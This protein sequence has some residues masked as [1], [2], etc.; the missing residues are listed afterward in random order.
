MLRCYECDGLAPVLS[1]RSRCTA[2]EEKRARSNELENEQLR[3]LQMAELR[4]VCE[5]WK[6]LVQPVYDYID[7]A[8]IDKLGEDKLVSLI[9]SHK[10]LQEEVTRLTRSR[11]E[12]AA[13]C[14]ELRTC[15]ESLVE[16]SDGLAGYHKNGA[17]ADWDELDVT[18]LLGEIPKASLQRND[19]EVAKAAIMV[20]LR[21]FA[22]PNMTYSHM[23]IFAREY[24]LRIMK[25]APNE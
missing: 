23:E 16:E 18:W 13:H 8:G 15:L 20:A 7:S 17:I 3:E 22:S 10:K 12:Y 11:N 25:G 2:C 14:D 21:N 24:A 5:E 9:E 1:S 19:A 6:Q 4:R